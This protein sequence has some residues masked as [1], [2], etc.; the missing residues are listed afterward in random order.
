MM[1]GSCFKER[2]LL[3]RLAYVRQSAPALNWM[4]TSAKSLDFGEEDGGKS[5]LQHSPRILGHYM[6]EEI[7]AI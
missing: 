3:L 6:Y 5:Q 2:F 4:L 7:V 1:G